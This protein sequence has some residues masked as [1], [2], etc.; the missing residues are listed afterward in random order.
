MRT[1]MFPCNR[2]RIRANFNVFVCRSPI[3]YLN[4]YKIP[5]FR[6]YLNLY[7][8]Y[9]LDTYVLFI[10]ILTLQVGIHA[11]V[12]ANT[13]SLQQFTHAG[14]TSENSHHFISPPPSPRSYF[15]VQ[16]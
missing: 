12:S 3:S 2:T 11:I 15:E 13:L 1:L 4:L 8:E 6:T 14:I 10:A 9:E 16:D 7:L 5:R